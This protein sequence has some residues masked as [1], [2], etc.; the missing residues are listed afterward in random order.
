MYGYHED[1]AM[2]RSLRQ[3]AEVD[4]DFE[5][6]KQEW[7]EKMDICEYSET[8]CCWYQVVHESMDAWDE[9]YEVREWEVS[10]L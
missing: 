9:R 10:K 8:Q 7:F 5:W 2:L 1:Q 3:V 4:T 6:A